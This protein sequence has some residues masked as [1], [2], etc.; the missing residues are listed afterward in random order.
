[1]S[2]IPNGRMRE[3]MHLRESRIDFINDKLIPAL[4]DKMLSIWEDSDVSTHYECFGEPSV[5]VHDGSSYDGFMSTSE[6]AITISANGSAGY[7]ISSGS[8]PSNEAAKE[9]LDGFQKDALVS[10]NES[11]LDEYAAAIESAG[12]SKDDFDTSDWEMAE[13]LAGIIDEDA[14]TL[15]DFVNQVEYE[16]HNDTPFNPFVRVI[17]HDDSGDGNYSVLTYAAISY[18]EYR[19]DDKFRDDTFENEFSFDSKTNLE[20]IVNRILDDVKKAVNSL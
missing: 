8:F 18:S 10:A 13:T 1:M 3:S 20:D 4:K 12:A 17:F 11:L 16:Y 9:R 7:V 5:E 2:F 19:L 15:Q 14:D 6:G